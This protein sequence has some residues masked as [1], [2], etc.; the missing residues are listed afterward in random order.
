MHADMHFLYNVY[1]YVPFFSFY[2]ILSIYY[3]PPFVPLPFINAVSCSPESNAG[4]LETPCK[5]SHGGRGT[6]RFRTP[7][8]L[9]V[10]T[11]PSHPIPS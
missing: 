2:Y 5:V 10:D 3:V 7:S 8:I 11:I 6:G 9:V 4:K 1:P